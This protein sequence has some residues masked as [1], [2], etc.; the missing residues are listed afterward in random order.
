MPKVAKSYYSAAIEH[1]EVPGRFLASFALPGEAPEWVKDQTGKPQLF[2]RAIEAELAGYRVLTAKLNKARA[3]QDFV[4]KGQRGG[5]R[6]YHAPE[7]E[8]KHTI[9]SVFGKR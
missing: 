8:E 7:R 6:T 3:I 2:K 1:R 4:P 5:I 9:Q